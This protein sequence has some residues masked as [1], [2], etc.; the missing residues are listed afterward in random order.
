MG[1]GSTYG[2]NPLVSSV[3]LASWEIL[4]EDG[5]LEGV[6][7]RAERFRASLLRIKSPR[8]KEVRGMGLMY[9]VE[10]FSIKAT[11]VLQALQHKGVVALPA[12]P[13]VVRFLPPLV[14]QD[15]HFD[16]VASAFGEALEE[17]ADE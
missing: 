3:A 11:P 6:M 15:R 5:F 2:G 16:R 10:L 17:C 13:T 1:H 4:H 7:E 12:G 14:A 9:G 8:V